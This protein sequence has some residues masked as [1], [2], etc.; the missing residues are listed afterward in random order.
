VLFGVNPLYAKLN[1]ICYLLAL[2][3]ANHILHVSRIRANWLVGCLVGCLVSLEACDN[4]VIYEV[5]VLLP[6]RAAYHSLPSS[7]EVMEE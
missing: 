4:L 1:P 5:M 7:A 6:G 3:G 2:L